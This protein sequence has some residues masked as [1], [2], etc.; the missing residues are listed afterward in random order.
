MVE[1]VLVFRA[2]HVYFSLSAD[3]QPQHTWLFFFAVTD[4]RIFVV[5]PHVQFDS[6]AQTEMI[7][8]QWLPFYKYIE[9]EQI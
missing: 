8:W 1:L 6:G 4:T 2:E 3:T 5:K 9:V 7:E